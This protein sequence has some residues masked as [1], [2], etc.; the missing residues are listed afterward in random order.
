LSIEETNKLL[1]EILST[2]KIIERKL[3][4]VA[5]A[6]S[7]ISTSD[8][9]IALDIMEIITKVFETDNNLYP[10]IK[11][12]LSLGGKATAQDIAV[13]THRSRSRENQHLNR[14]VDLGYIAKH[15]EGREI[16]FMLNQE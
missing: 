13:S 7:A 10:T 4:N 11:A 5:S 16:Y 1:T 3:E 12:L 15:R 6:S 9:S 2:L 14:L 8:S